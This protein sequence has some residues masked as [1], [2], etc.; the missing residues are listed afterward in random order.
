MEVPWKEQCKFCQKSFNT[1]YC[2]K[3]QRIINDSINE[4]EC[5]YFVFDSY[6]FGNKNA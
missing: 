5:P 4:W 3:N 6:I 2:S 1:T